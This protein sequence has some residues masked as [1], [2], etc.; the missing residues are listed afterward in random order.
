MKKEL[1]LLL[2]STMFVTNASFAATNYNFEE[3]NKPEPY[4]SSKP[5]RGY[6]VSVPAGSVVP[7]VTT[8]DFSS[9]TL[10]QGQLVQMAL[11]SDFYYE[12]KLIAPAGS[13][14]TGTV[15]TCKKATWGGINGKLK[16]TFTQIT[17]PQ[18]IQIPING[19]IKTTDGSGLLVGGTKL[20]VAKEYT[21]DAA[22]GAAIGALSGVV[23]G[24]LAGGSV[25]RGA[26][27]GT[28]VGAGGGLVKG[29]ATKGAD[30][31][32]PVNSSVDI[33]LTQ[34]ITVQPSNYS[35]EE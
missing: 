10:T 25:G 2:I 33:I 28:A 16:I 34:P 29:G 7:A 31:E 4:S 11:G 35:Y 6:L 17:T 22:A 5:L 26:A 19:I 27:L 3:P 15:V 32:I 21:K 9:N 30:V 13:M 23:F 18:G 24:A 20:D 12:N 14:L 8:M 1:S